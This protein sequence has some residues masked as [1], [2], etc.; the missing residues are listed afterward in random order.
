MANIREC[1]ALAHVTRCFEDENV[2]HVNN[3][4]D[5]VADIDIINTELLLAD[6]ES[7]TKQIE[8]FKR[9]LERKM[10]KFS[11]LHF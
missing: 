5:P 9:E 2:T 6:L 8:S 4:I 1:D 3:V 7:V 11:A 10:M